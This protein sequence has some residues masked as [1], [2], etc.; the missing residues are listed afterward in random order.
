MFEELHNYEVSR[1]F[2]SVF[3]LKRYGYTFESRLNAKDGWEKKVIC[4][5]L[6]NGTERYVSTTFPNEKRY[7]KFLE[8]SSLLKKY[9]KLHPEIFRVYE[10]ERTV[11]CQY[12]GE[13]LPPL[14]LSEEAYSAIDAVRDYLVLLNSTSLREETFEVPCGLEGFFEL[15][16]QLPQLLLSFISETKDI[17]PRLRERGIHFPYGSGIED[18]DIKNFRIL[19][20]DK[21]VSS[22]GRERFRALT[23]DYDCWSEKINCFWATGYFYAS[24]RWLDEVSPGISRKCN[25]YI[26][27]TMN[28]KDQ[29]EEFMFWL[30]AFSGYCRY[31]KAIKQAIS[32]HRMDEF[33]DKLEIIKELN[34]KVFHLAKR[35]IEMKEEEIA[36]RNGLQLSTD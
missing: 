35:L 28:F 10:E 3:P 18:P 19:R 9:R 26:L 16:D 24:L 17:L 36:H 23:T 8:V 25:E 31:K 32:E 21:E 5:V 1:D 34:K 29:R 33:Q 11:V 2:L 4:S 30:G 7:L 14:L 27:R 20:E 15:S 13:F 6:K 22:G 12:T